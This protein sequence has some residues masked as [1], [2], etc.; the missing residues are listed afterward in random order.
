MSILPISRAIP[1][2]KAAI[3]AALAPLVDL[4]KE[5]LPSVYWEQATPARVYPCIVFQSQ[6]NGGKAESTIGG[7]GWSG[8]F[9]IKV[10][11]LTPDDVDA[12][13][14]EIELAMASA[15]AADGYDLTVLECY[16]LTLPSGD[17]TA[18]GGLIFRISVY[19][20]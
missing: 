4:D 11:A 20:Q 12:L 2:V 17:T 6:D 9:A 10:Y 3:L 1:I 5:G 13:L 14:P 16:P 8:L 7:R 18:A 15:S 19:L